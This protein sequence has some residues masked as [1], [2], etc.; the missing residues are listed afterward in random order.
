MTVTR[1]Y[2]CITGFD[3]KSED[4][5]KITWGFAEDYVGMMELSPCNPDLHPRHDLH[6]LS[7]KVHARGDHTQWP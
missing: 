2:E 5:L 4:S 6:H 1:V 3:E 7:A